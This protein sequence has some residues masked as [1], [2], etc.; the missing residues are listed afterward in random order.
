MAGRGN[1]ETVSDPI[2]IAHGD[3]LDADPGA[4]NGHLDLARSHADLIPELPWNDHSP[5]LVDGCSHG[6][7]IPCN[8]ATIGPLDARWTA[9]A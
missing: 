3:R 4:V 8:L 9:H 7:K 2:E 1:D 6:C 5:C